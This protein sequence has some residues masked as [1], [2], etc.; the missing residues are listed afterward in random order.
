MEKTDDYEN[1][2]LGVP[3]EEFPRPESPPPKKLKK[4][5]KKEISK[6]EATFTPEQKKLAIEEMWEPRKCSMAFCNAK[7]A[8][9]YNYHDNPEIN[10]SDKQMAEIMD[11]HCIDFEYSKEKGKK[12]GRIHYQG[13][14]HYKR[15]IRAGELQNLL[16][17]INFRLAPM[18]SQLAS[19]IYCKKQDTHVSGPWTKAKPFGCRKDYALS[20]LQTALVELHRQFANDEIDPGRRKVVIIGQRL[21]NL[22]RSYASIVAT[23]KFG[24]TRVSAMKANDVSYFLYKQKLKNLNMVT[25]DC[26]RDEENWVSWKVVEGLKNGTIAAGKYDS[27]IRNIPPAVV[28]IYCNKWPRIFNQETGEYVVSD[29]RFIFFRMNH[30]TMFNEKTGVYDGTLSR[31][32]LAQVEAEIIEQRPSLGNFR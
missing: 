13:W 18:M 14:L 4:G 8:F 11:E 15:L 9:T 19:E 3:E 28:F 6:L 26:S 10:F 1:P 31:L 24:G 5:E 27:D 7:F 23:E 29:D 32:T 30:T 16:G 12:N 21:G 22:G 25:W 2:F 17:D 20:P